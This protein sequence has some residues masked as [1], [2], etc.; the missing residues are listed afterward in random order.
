MMATI[1][2]SLRLVLLVGV[3]SRRCSCDDEGVSVYESLPRFAC[4]RDAVV[5]KSSDVSGDP[6]LFFVHVFKAAGSSVRGIFR[7]YAEKCGKRWACLVMC[8]DGGAPNR[9]GVLP[10]RLRDTVNLNRAAV[11]EPNMGVSGKRRMRRNPDA[12]G[13]GVQAHIIGGH[14]HYGM[15]AILPPER[16]RARG[17]ES[18]SLHRVMFWRAAIT[19][20]THPRGERGES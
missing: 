5:D 18:P 9:N 16:P 4:A 20:G 3:L 13:L 15:H 12:D 11:I 7:R 17:V 19:E 14:Y 2:R 10:C 6:A 8:S 1:R